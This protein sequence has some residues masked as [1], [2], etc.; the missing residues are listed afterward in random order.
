MVFAIAGLLCT[1]PTIPVAAGDESRGCTL[2]QLPAEMQ[3]HI[4]TKYSSWRLQ[5]VSDLA[6]NAKE[7]WESEKPVDCPGIAV[8]QFE[9]ADQKSYAALLVPANK[10]D[11]GYRL[12]VFTP[13][14]SLSSEAFRVID[15]SDGI[16]ASNFFIH[17]IK[18]AKVFSSE[19]VKKL[20]VVTKDGILF[21]DAGTSEYEADVYFWTGEM[22]RHDAIDY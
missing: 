17:Q 8:G 10:P 13:N 5:D 3:R 11:T 15:Q 16:G 20:R 4:Q 21:V 19:W 2:T 7:R 18:I 6:A 22:Y 14:G 1:V 12:L 9:K